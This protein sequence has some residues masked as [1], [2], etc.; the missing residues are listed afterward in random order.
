[1]TIE[2]LAAI[3]VIYLDSGTQKII[4]PAYKTSKIQKYG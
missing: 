4:S 1:M 2:S 3:Q